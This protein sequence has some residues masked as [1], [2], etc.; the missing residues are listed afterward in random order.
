MN[1]Q[2]AVAKAFK[3]WDA[4]SRD[5]AGE[6]VSEVVKDAVRIGDV[7]TADP[8]QPVPSLDAGTPAPRRA[9]RR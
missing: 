7:A 9:P 2:P 1:N 8:V 4:L 5:P 3:N 6:K